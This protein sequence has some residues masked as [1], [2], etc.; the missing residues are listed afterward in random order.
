MFLSI[1]QEVHW[2]HVVSYFLV[3]FGANL[4][5]NFM[6]TFLSFI[7]KSKDYYNVPGDE[8]ASLIGSLGFYAEICVLIFD[9]LLG[10]VMDIFGRKLPIIIGF[11]I[12][13][14]AVIVIPFS[15]SALPSLFM[16]R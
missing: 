6:N 9:I 14:I 4:L 16:L 3:Q 5:L 13:A 15:Q 2:Y 12:A 7:V 10:S 1:N 11:L 8:A